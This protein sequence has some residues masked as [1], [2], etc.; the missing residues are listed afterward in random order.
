IYKE[1]THKESYHAY[2]TLHDV[3]PIQGFAQVMSEPRVQSWILQHEAAVVFLLSSPG[4]LQALDVNL[5]HL[6]LFL[7]ISTV[8]IRRTFGPGPA[9]AFLGLVLSAR[10]MTVL[11]GGPFDFRLD[12]AAMCAWDALV[13]VLA[14][15]GEMRTW[16]QVAAVVLLGE[17]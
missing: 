8:C 6:L 12:F 17:L 3:D 14:L 16:R 5:A 15:A 2:A 7:G 10:T 1:N 11:I 9:L 13:A 4:R